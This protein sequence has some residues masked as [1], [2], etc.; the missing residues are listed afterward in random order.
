MPLRP[1]PTPQ[2]KPPPHEVVFLCP[3]LKKT[4]D[5]LLD[6]GVT[7]VISGDLSVRRRSRFRWILISLWRAGQRWVSHECVDLS[8][9]FA[10]F[11]LQSIFP[12]LLIAFSVV[13]N[14]IGKADSLDYL[15]ASLSPILPPAALELVETTL[16]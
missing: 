8:A 1:T 15:F 9:A 7:V 4:D 5:G 11:A 3:F 12:L 6:I 2:K 14:V 16:S 13:A 10:Y